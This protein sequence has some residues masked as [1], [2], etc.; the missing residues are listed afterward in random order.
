MSQIL[1]LSVDIL[2]ALRLNILR[3][4]K[5]VSFQ[6]HTPAIFIELYKKS[7]YHY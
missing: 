5:V 6:L 7:I 2:M 3:N 1:K 4:S